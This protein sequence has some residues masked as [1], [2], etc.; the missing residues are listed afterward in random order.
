MSAGCGVTQTAA[1]SYAVT[2]KGGMRAS[3]LYRKSGDR[4]AGWWAFSGTR[5]MYCGADRKKAFDAAVY[6]CGGMPGHGR[7]RTEKLWD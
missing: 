6:L 7:E 2:G 1:Y 3:V 5:K 4:P